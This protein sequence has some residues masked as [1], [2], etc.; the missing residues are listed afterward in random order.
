MVALFCENPQTDD[1]PVDH[2]TT[3]LRKRSPAI[4][5][6]AAWA[7]YYYNVICTPG[8]SPLCSSA[9]SASDTDGR[10]SITNLVC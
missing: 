6:N 8:A 2:S 3:L 5:S 1:S 4:S 9:C 7:G 10:I